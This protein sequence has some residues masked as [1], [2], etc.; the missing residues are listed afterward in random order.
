MVNSVYKP[1]YPVQTLEK[2][3]DIL[4]CLKCANSSSGMGLAE[5]SE[6]LDM[7]KSVVHRILDTL[8]A[9]GFV[10]KVEGS[11]TTYRL[12]WGIYDI[13]QAVPASH[14]LNEAV[15]QKI[16]EQLCTKCME[17]VNLGIYNNGEVVIICKM[18]PDRRLR[19]TVEIGER[20]PLYATALGKQFLSHFTKEEVKDYFTKADIQPITQNTIV[21][22][23]DMYSELE[24]VKKNG[25]SID[26]ME[27]CD[28]LICTAV[29]VFDYKNELIAAISIS[30]PSSRFTKEKSQEIIQELKKAGEA[31]SEYLG[32]QKEV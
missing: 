12:G 32:Y 13:A 24:I 18:E 6:K 16:L 15:Y 10:E 20:E 1:K 19:S 28:D 8:Y 11:V 17:T 27:F 7:G 3:I 21:S 2:A 9:Y 26:N 25:Y 22:L 23:D 14:N 31:L 30:V 5:I 4:L 29:P